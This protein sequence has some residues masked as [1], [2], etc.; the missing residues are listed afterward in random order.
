MLAGWK[1]RHFESTTYAYT[2]GDLPSGFTHIRLQMRKHL[3]THIIFAS[4]ALP[5]TKYINGLSKEYGRCFSRQSDT[6]I[7]NAR[8]SKGIQ[9][10]KL[11]GKEYRGILLLMLVMLQS[12]GGRSILKSARSGNFKY[13]HQLDDWSMLVELLLLWEAYLLEPEMVVRDVK[14][15]ELKNRYIMY[16][17]RQVANRKKGMGLKLVKFHG[18]LHLKDDILLYGVPLET[19]TSSNESHHKP[20]KLASKLTQMSHSTLNFQTAKRMVDFEAIDFAILELEEG[21]V[22]W[23]YYKNLVDAEDEGQEGEVQ[24]MDV[25]FDQTTQGFGHEEKRDGSATSEDTSRASNGGSSISQPVETVAGDALIEVFRDPESGDA[26]YKMI[27]RSVHKNKTL[28]NSQLVNWLLE[29]QDLLDKNNFLPAHELRIYTRI[30]R[31]DQSFCGH[32]TTETRVLGETGLG[33]ILERRVMFPATC[34]V[35]L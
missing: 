10:G 12:H 2:Q 6:S 22:I 27:S 33:S 35:S 16:L 26:A 19:D 4:M 5:L 24:D 13:D 23:D 14:K 25:S 1:I 18:V 29:L 20:M 31:G 32:Q 15:L 8:F 30:K 21:V 9:E 34:G 3:D 11:M 17:M 7:P 28:L